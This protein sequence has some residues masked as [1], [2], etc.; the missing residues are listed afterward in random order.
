MLFLDYVYCF[1]GTRRIRV[2]DDKKTGPNA[3]HIVW[4]LG[5]FF[6]VFFLHFID[7][8]GPKR[9]QM[10]RLGRCF[11]CLSPYQ[12]SAPHPP[13]PSLAQTMPTKAHEGPQLSAA[14]KDEEGPKRRQTHCLGHGYVSFLMF[15]FLFLFLLLRDPAP[16]PSLANTSRGWVFWEG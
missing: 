2:S 15:N 13:H 3:R 1:E 10:R 16:H 7:N 14:N 4:A 5:V 8:N 12:P 6:F 9:P 11:V